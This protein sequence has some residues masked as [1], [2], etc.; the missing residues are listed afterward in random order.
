MFL[1]TSPLWDFYLCIG[2]VNVFR[3]ALVLIFLSL[4]LNIERFSK[5]IS[6]KMMYLFTGIIC[7]AVLFLFIY[8]Q[9][10]D[11]CTLVP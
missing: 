9:C 4:Y 3:V 5:H 1:G 2:I 11:E 6:Y 10:I 7:E 8:T